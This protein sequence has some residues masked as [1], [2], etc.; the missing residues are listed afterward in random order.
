MSSKCAFWSYP[1]SYPHYPQMDK[2]V[3]NN[4]NILWFSFKI[5][6]YLKPC[7]LLSAQSFTASAIGKLFL[8]HSFKNAFSAVSVKVAFF[9]TRTLIQSSTWF[10]SAPSSRS[11]FLKSSLE[12]ETFFCA[13]FL[14]DFG[15]CWFSQDWK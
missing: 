1:Q 5:H 2:N 8:L 7:Q 11:L 10:N 15:N 4:K 12:K 3:K 13:T 6:W 14:E 9:E